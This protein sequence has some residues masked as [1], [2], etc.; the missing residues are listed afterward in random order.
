MCFRGRRM[1]PCY[2]QT[3]H[4]INILRSV[5][6]ICSLTTW[7]YVMLL[8]AVLLAAGPPYCEVSHTNVI[9]V[10]PKTVPSMPIDDMASGVFVL[11]SK[12]QCHLLCNGHVLICEFL[13]VIFQNRNLFI[14]GQAK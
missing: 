1:G 14:A 5:I 6:V 12:D 13:T 7:L 8:A 11:R 9:I 4:S 10:G 2:W 3:R